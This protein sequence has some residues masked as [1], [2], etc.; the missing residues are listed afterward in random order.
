MVDID[1]IS[2]LIATAS[3]VVGV[4]NSILVSKR[5]DIQR[6]LKLF[7]QIYGKIYDP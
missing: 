2:I 4:F 6:Q 1:T 5:F 7:M 3:V